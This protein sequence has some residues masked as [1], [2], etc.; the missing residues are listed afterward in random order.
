MLLEAAEGNGSALHKIPSWMKGWKSPWRNKVNGGELIT[1]GEEELYALGIRTRN[2]FPH[3]FTQDYH[4]D[5]YTM[6]AT[7]VIFAF[8]V[9]SFVL[10][11]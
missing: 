7:Q 4:P 2:L 3:L 11:L 1:Q 8:C 9:F 10:Y 6:K 5:V